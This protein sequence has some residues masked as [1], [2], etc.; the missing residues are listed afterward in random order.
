MSLIAWIFLGLIAGSIASRVVSKRGE[1]FVVDIALGIAGAVVGGV[2]F[3]W[4]GAAGVT[5]F[6][7]YSICV[8]LVGAVAVLVAYHALFGRRLSA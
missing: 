3:T 6:N 7:L 4:M 5:G 8:A 1:S 2:F